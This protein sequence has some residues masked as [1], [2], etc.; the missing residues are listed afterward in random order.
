MKWSPFALPLLG[1]LLC[2]P[3]S[4]LSLAALSCREA[5]SELHAATQ[6]SAHHPQEHQQ[7]TLRSHA[8]THHKFRYSRTE[9]T[10]SLST[11]RT[12]DSTAGTAS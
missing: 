11:P 5:S 4:I 1:S 9:P 10:S 12:M 7:N 6:H 3:Y 8:P 2:C